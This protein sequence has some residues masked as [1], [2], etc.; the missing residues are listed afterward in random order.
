MRRTF[1]RKRLLFALA[2]FLLWGCAATTGAPT[3]SAAALESQL[4]V[5]SCGGAYGDAI[6]EAYV[7]PFAEDTAIQVTYDDDCD[8]QT[9]QLAA[10]SEAGQVQWDVIAGFGGPVYADLHNRGLLKTIDHDV[11]GSTDVDLTQGA[12]QPY[13][14][15]LHNDAVVVGYSLAAF[16]DGISG[17]DTFF[18]P[19]GHPGTRAM[20]IGGFEDWT[21]PSLALVAD[22]V[23]P[24][25]LI[26][27]DWDRAFSKM[28]AIK[29][30]VIWYKGGTEML[31][32]MLEDQAV[33][34]L[35]SDARMLQ[36][37]KQD[38]D[39]GVSY[40]DG[41]RTVIFWA[42]PEGA[43]HPN[44][45]LEFLRSTL[46]AQRQ[47]DFTELIG[48]SGVVEDS[49][50][51]LSSDLQSQV[52]VNPGNFSKTWAFTAEQNEWLAEHAS[53]AS[54]NYATWTGQ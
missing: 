54:D 49:Y 42:I 38:S 11:V 10:Q 7:Q 28:D 40:D 27:L 44:A 31:A 39:I 3:P 47:A 19:A 1:E 5:N 41:L 21:R 22:G 34:C 25:D 17:I 50:D 46:D 45:A 6:Q 15:G 51:L 53:E 48:Y 26:P 23:E 37:Q 16:P 2:L 24:D 20:T 30:D 36:A 13:G 29:D 43:P 33:I 35:C 32:T 18:D 12:L 9:T 4:V 8:A 14:L 52:L